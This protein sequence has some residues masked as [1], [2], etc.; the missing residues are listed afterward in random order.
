MLFGHYFYPNCNDIQVLSKE[1]AEY[2]Q[3]L[4]ATMSSFSSENKNQ[5]KN[6]N[7]LHLCQN[8]LYE[9]MS[10]KFIFAFLYMWTETKIFLGKQHRK[11]R[12]DKMGS[13]SQWER[14]I[15]FILPAQWFSQVIK[16]SGGLPV[17]I[18]YDGVMLYIRQTTCII[19]IARVIVPFFSGN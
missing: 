12:A 9:W 14:S 8:K 3:I 11:F 4:L 16:R 6:L 1:W 5:F 2:H 19:R 13:G 18:I 10:T 17:R 7:R 15:P